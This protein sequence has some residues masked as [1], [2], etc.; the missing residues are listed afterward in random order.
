MA[1]DK[2]YGE[3]IRLVGSKKM[4]K[5]TYAK[6]MERLKWL[7]ISRLFSN[8]NGT[9]I[10]RSA[11]VH[12][13]LTARNSQVSASVKIGRNVT[14]NSSSLAEYTNI[15]DNCFLY[16]AD[17][18]QF[19]YSNVHTHLLRVK[20]GK[21]CSIASHV[22]IGAAPHPMDRVSTHPLTFLKEYGNFIESDDPDVK[23]MREDT[24]TTI[25]NDVWIGQAVLI[26]PNVKVGD[27]A[28]IG[29]H[30]VVTKDVEPYS[31]VVGNPAR[32]QRYRFSPEVIKK[33]LSIKWWEWDQSKIKSAISDFNHTDNFVAKYYRGSK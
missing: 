31:V 16:K 15:Y 27:G 23:S 9:F 13:S 32:V 10:H 17:I 30:A 1:D 8:I 29:A 19:S 18:G 3:E 26:L 21:F 11:K 33:M 5:I 22:Y 20:I 25:G 28:I 2:I 24:I 14:L 6:V 4:K 12:A 7:R